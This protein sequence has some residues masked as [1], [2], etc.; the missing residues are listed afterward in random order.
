MPEGLARALSTPV[1]SFQ[2]RGHLALVA[3]RLDQGDIEKL[4]GEQ[5]QKAEQ[6]HKAQS[7]LAEDQIK[8]QNLAKAAAYL[9]V[10]QNIQ[11]TLN[12]AAA[13]AMLTG[14]ISEGLGFL[15]S[16][17]AAIIQ[18]L[19]VYTTRGTA[20][21]KE[22]R[23]LQQ[24]A[25]MFEDNISGNIFSL[26]GNHRVEVQKAIQQ[27][28]G[29]DLANSPNIEG[30]HIHAMVPRPD[31]TRP[32]LNSLSIPQTIISS[33]AALA[34]ST[35]MI[36]IAQATLPV[37]P[38]QMAAMASVV[39]GQTIQS[40]MPTNIIPASTATFVQAISVPQA[41]TP[42]MTTIA[43]PS[44]ITTSVVQA[45]VPAATPVIAQ[46]ASPVAASS[47]Q[48]V[49]PSSATPATSYQPTALQADRPQ[50]AESQSQPTGNADVKASAKSEGF[51][52]GKHNLELDRAKDSDRWKV[53][54]N[55]PIKYHSISFRE[56]AK[57]TAPENAAPRN[58]FSSGTAEQSS[59]VQT[60]Q[61]QQQRQVA[62]VQQQQVAQVQ[63]Q[64]QQE[65]QKVVEAKIEQRQAEITDYYKE[66]PRKRWEA[67]GASDDVDEK[68]DRKIV[69]RNDAPEKLDD[70]DDR[71]VQIIANDRDEADDRLKN[72]KKVSY[73][74]DF[75][76]ADKDQGRE[77]T[78][79]FAFEN[80]APTESKAPSTE[81][82][83]L[84]ADN[85]NEGIKGQFKQAAKA[86]C[87][88]CGGG[89]CATCTRG[90]ITAQKDAAILNLLNG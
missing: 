77:S 37:L 56:D 5:S 90:Q 88:G 73:A 58:V 4:W 57:P 64:Q 29:I 31:N 70:R 62:Q 81:D 47:T 28:K 86:G 49:S 46:T 25:R 36:A 85:D 33:P 22:T 55:D 21:A 41:G 35:S 2:N 76:V 89:N 51:D 8:K 69:F 6:S 82:K 60:P 61:Q 18:S 84:K 20:E 45:V 68:G 66:D 38:T 27:L 14:G 79:V 83:T 11:N 42:V 32:V 78:Q 15:L 63:Q 9:K 1:R 72:D 87:A 53:G 7:T 10:A 52:W 74:D 44:A 40:V 75:R 24:S 50:Q 16:S 17:T 54:A 65:V 34:A 26:Q 12:R 59:V 71:R 19:E 3:E 80:K 30:S 13:D 48:S 43:A 67:K 23:L 39:T